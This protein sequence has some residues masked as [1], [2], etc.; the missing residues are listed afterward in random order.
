MRNINRWLSK[1]SVTHLLLDGGTLS[2]KE[3]F[4]SDYVHD[5]THGEKLCVVEKKTPRFRFFVDVDY[6]SDENEL[7]FVMVS[8]ELFRIV[9]LGSCVLAKAHPRKTT[10]GTK[11]GMHIIWPESLVTKQTAN[12]IRMKLL[13]EFGSDWEDVFDS[14]VYS[15]SGL[16]ML[17]S[18]KNEPGSTPY[19]P[20]G[21][22]D[23]GGQF[24]EFKNKDPSTHFLEL[25]SIRAPY[26]TDAEPVSVSDAP[27]KSELESFIMKNIPGQSNIRISR[28]GKC[29]NKKDYWIRTNSKYCDHVKREHKSNNVW[30]I[31]SPKGTLCQM[32]EDEECKKWKGRFY[33][34]PSHLIPNERVLDSSPRCCIIDYLPN[35]WKLNL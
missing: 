6:V 25:F 33:R 15:G 12:T 18:Y 28:I 19:V 4:Y 16:R 13:D 22:F 34:I 30:F 11:Y 32:C 8:R 21:R 2:A 31:L 7:D 10:K 29:K 5:V 35:G 14:S 20:F 9:N 26:E 23:D 3:G 27:P 1:T 24:K 17:W